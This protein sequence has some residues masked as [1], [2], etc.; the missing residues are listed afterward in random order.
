MAIE[1]TKVV[2]G[3]KGGG[4]IWINDIINILYTYVH[5]YI[6]NLH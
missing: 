5:I 6:T 2:A 1:A 4:Y 3:F